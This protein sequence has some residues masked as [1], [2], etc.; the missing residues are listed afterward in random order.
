MEIDYKIRRKKLIE[1]K[2]AP[3]VVCIFS[4]SAP[5]KSLDEAYPF[6]VDRNF[7]Y[8]TG[9]EKE[10]TTSGLTPWRSSR[11]YSTSRFDRSKS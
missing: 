8:L 10:N 6:S 1:G 2:E 9:I 4:G 11:W 7:Y 5:M 3:C